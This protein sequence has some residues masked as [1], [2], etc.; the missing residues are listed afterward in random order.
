MRPKKRPKKS[1][2][3]SQNNPWGTPKK[4]IVRSQNTN[5]LRRAPK[6]N[7][8]YAPMARFKE[9]ARTKA[10][11]G[12]TRFQKRRI[13]ATSSYAIPKK[14][15]IAWLPGAGGMFQDKR[16]IAIFGWKLM[17]FQK[18]RTIAE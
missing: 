18:R 10:I 13:I 14:R 1:V 16:T 15:R 17:C 7:L 4:P 12:G 2:I 5:S 8:S 11:L 3:H 6:Q 9:S